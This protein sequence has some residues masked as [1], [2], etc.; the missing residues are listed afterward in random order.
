M[1]SK[2]KKIIIVFNSLKIGG[3][4][5][6]IVDICNY[7]SQKYKTK[8]F[9]YLKSFEGP[10]LKLIPPSV[11]IIEPK[12]PKIFKLR[13]LLFP[14]WLASN[15]RRVNPDLILAFGNYSAISAISAKILS[16]VQSN[17]VI[18]EDSSI[19]T[20][21]K[22]DS[23]SFIRTQMVKLLYHYSNSLIV[24]SQSGKNN[25]LKIVPSQKSK[26]VIL[27]NWLP[28]SYPKINNNQ[29]RDI[30][31]IF[32]GRFEPQKNP[33]RFLDISK[34]LISINP[35]LK[36]VIV[37]YG[38]LKNK[39]KKYISIYKLNSNIILYPQ[40]TKAYK[41]FER[42]KIFLLSSDHEGFPLTILES[43]ASGSLPICVDLPEIRKYF[44]LQTSSL[45]Y[46]TNDKAI[47]NIKSLLNNQIK[48]NQLSDYYQQ[49]TINNQQLNFQKT[50]NFINKHL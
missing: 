17:I 23:F 30:D 18:S 12:I 44:N 48:L 31:I 10:N 35:K 28:L 46:N 49:K 39:I 5:T 34:S 11:K 36:V 42:S 25:L 27:E 4:E 8:V 29:N 22:S 40:T 15:I 41:Y 2:T 43:T 7:Y 32:L 13:S 45:L 16:C 1:K 20:Q 38:S 21:L 14:L 24:L 26:I 50:I 33:F 9:L 3:I 47:K 19:T 6:K 37:G